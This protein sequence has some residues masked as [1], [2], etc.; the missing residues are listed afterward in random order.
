MFSFA[1]APGAKA[2]SAEAQLPAYCRIEGRNDTRS[3]R[4]LPST[5]K[6]ASAATIPSVNHGEDMSPTP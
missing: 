6:N 4:R 5:G 1:S 3:G 2:H